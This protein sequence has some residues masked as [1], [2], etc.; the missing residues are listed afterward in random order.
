MGPQ[1]GCSPSSKLIALQRRR[2]GY[3]VGS[4]SN[5]LSKSSARRP[6]QVVSVR[7]TAWTPKEPRPSFVRQP[8]PVLSDTPVGSGPKVRSIDSPVTSESSAE[9]LKAAGSMCMGGRVVNARIAV[10]RSTTALRLSR[11]AASVA[12]DAGV[13]GISYSIDRS[14]SQPSGGSAGGRVQTTRVWPF[15][16]VRI[17]ASISQL[18]AIIWGELP[19]IRRVLDWSASVGQRGDSVRI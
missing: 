14:K 13:P 8:M 4:P 11:R 10:R 18:R 6:R 7:K 3:A 9:Y 1:V 2:C 17:Q 5:S 15:D 12:T 16:D 19:T